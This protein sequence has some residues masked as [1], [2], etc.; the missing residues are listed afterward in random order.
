MLYKMG[1]AA[2]GEEHSRLHTTTI[3]L[4]S[5]LNVMTDSE[6][7]ERYRN[8]VSRIQQY[9]KNN[10]WLLIGNQASE[11]YYATGKL[12]FTGNTQ[13]GTFMGSELIER[14]DRQAADYRRLPLI[15]YIKRGHDTDD[16][17]D[18][19]RDLEPWMQ[20]HHYTPVYEDDDLTIFTTQTS[21]TPN[22]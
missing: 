16:M 11:L 15:V 4:P 3:A 5:T 20:K 12:P 10:P 9:G 2:Q 8:E 7:A 19:R 1:S 13:M 14:L 22:K 21:L 18:F 6:R 17:P